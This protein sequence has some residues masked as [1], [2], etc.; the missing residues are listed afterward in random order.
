[1]LDYNPYQIYK[2]YIFLKQHFT[3]WDF[4]WG[5]NISYKVSVES[6]KNRKDLFFFKRLFKRYSERNECAQHIISG[7]LYDNDIWVGQLFDEQIDKFHSDRM[8]RFNSIEFT[9]AQDCE[10][11][12][13][14]RVSVENLFLTK[15]TGDAIIYTF[16]VTLETLSVL[17]HFNQ[18]ANH[19][20]PLNPIK[21]Q[22]RT[23]IHKY[24]FLLQ[25]NTRKYDSMKHCYQSLLQS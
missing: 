24:S 10:S 15:G 23:Q 8:K 11:I 6:F 19:W 17:N 14:Q 22:R 2:D 9:F 1:M 5:E 3:H 25:L 12:K 13:N 16:G 7:F 18:W 20:F 21:K 4:I